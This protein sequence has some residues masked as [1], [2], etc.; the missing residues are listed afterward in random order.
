MRLNSIK[1]SGFKSFAEPTNFVLPGQLIGVV[2]PNGCGKSN[3]MD[4]VRWVLGESK[5][6][7]LRGE[8][9]QDVIFNGTNLRKP[10]SRSSVELVFDNADHRAGG[11]WGQFAE[12][13]V[14]RVLTRDGTSSYYLNNQPVRRRDVQ[15]V[16]LGTGLGPRAYAIIGQGTISRIIESKP[17]ELRLFLEEAAGV[18]KYKER[19][20]ET[21]NR[22]SDTRENLTRV[23]DILRELN[24]N[25][26][27]LEKQAEVALRY[28][29][30][31]ADATLKQHQL[32][33]LKRAESE[34]DQAK[35]KADAAK[36]VNDLESR[37]ADLRHIEADL[38]TIR[39]AHYAAGD[40]V[41]QAQGKLYE[42]S[43]EV[44]RLE[45]EI[46]FVVEGRQRVEQRLAQLKEQTSQWAARKED[47]ALETETLTERAIQAE[48]QAELLAAQSEDQAGQLPAL[49]EALRAAQSKANEQ[50]TSVGQVQQQ[51][52]VLA[53]DQRNIEEQ[54]RTLSLR[55]E[56]LTAD[57]NALN[58]PDEARL[59][60]LNT[61]FAAAKEAQDEAEARLH[62]L[63]DS[64]PQLDEDRRNKQQA[65]N[66]ESARQAELSAR[67]EALKALQEK[68]KTDGKLKPWLAKHGLDGLQGL[69]SRIHIEQGWENALEA[70][71]RERLGALE[72]SRLDMVRG[73]AGTDGR[74][75]P[76]AKLS[77]YSPPTATAPASASAS[78]LK[79][80]ADFL[81]LGD[82]GQ[83]AL[84]GD[85]L[86]GCL[87]AASLDE[88]LAA[89]HQLQA[90]EVIY[91]KSGHAVTLHS[92]SFYAQDS[93]Q[94]GLLARAQEIENLE[95]QLRAQALISDEARSAL[96]R[97][98][99]AYAD[100]A[101]RLATARRET[102]EGQSRTHELQVEVLRL[103][104]LAEQTRARSEQIAGDLAEIDA[105]MNDLQERRVTA[106]GR[107]EELDMQLADSQERHA[108]LDD[109]VIEAERKLN[110]SR[111][112]QRALERQSQE[113]QFALRSL[114]SRRDEL[115][116]S[117]DIAAQQAASIAGEEERAK[118]ELSRLT[119]AAA[120]AGL[121][122]AL[123]VKLEREADL[124]AKRSQY[125]DL[126]TKLRASD[127]RRLQLERELDPLR[128]RI[129]EFQLKEQAARLGFEQYA[130]L[131][132][133]AQADLAAVEQSIQTGN[134]R[135]TGLQGEI[136][137][138]N[139]DIQSLG[140]V[141]LAALDELSSA[142]ERKQ[143]LDA[144]SADLNEAMTTLE[145]AI[146]KI[147]AETRDLL[148]TTFETVNRHFGEMFPRLF[149][150]GNAKLV[151]TGE[152]IL[153]AGVQVLAQPP[154]K[155][156]QTIHLLSGGEK[157]L[158]AIALVFAIF[159]LN[160]APF[161][162]LDEVDAPLDDANTERYA[163]LVASMSKETQFLFISHNKIAMEMAEQLIGVT[164]QEQGVSRIVAVDMEAALG[165]A[166]AA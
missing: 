99:A 23:E 139:R 131:L 29:T 75:T 117:I 48:E 134:V 77:F 62:E 88:A 27:K 109:R 32:W 96:I 145:D 130:Q 37:I 20:R 66:T 163:K 93:E 104:Q 43:A 61:Q 90:G 149:G 55:H 98:E 51:I 157:A 3:I 151:M 166:E 148:S 112:Q 47:A 119:D 14:K 92:V 83:T 70:A 142:R 38:E 10:A 36:S 106:E 6:S 56:R 87:T 158:T 97:A 147:D 59:V 94:A 68:V 144:Q 13:A 101:Q 82:A 26:E 33:F 152:E 129:T 118:E 19:R 1:L 45:A 72:V 95:K 132:A 17:E 140:A 141:N 162:L 71:L 50:R 7:E 143:F 103:T 16:F 127:E 110:E 153:D 121:Q 15:D 64:V 124:G 113:A 128:Q 60:N 21:A 111:E 137:R 58:A 159:Q 115:T 69:W 67:L 65:V 79:P 12:I 135:L 28:N 31:H 100:A 54:S 86:H 18:S 136:D 22:L 4:A 80:L 24:A 52:Q 164:M 123:N 150:G 57:K 146:K 11:Q 125:D 138:I 25:L 41:N 39:Q 91:V 156:N 42:A 73:F 108:Q 78:G 114:A 53:A 89:R 74:D 35:V 8:S 49:E 40:Q 120:Q 160:P 34:A 5:A 9:M 126:T 154:G 76:P 44:G 116:R 165:F 2:G 84:L 107:F 81:R 161:C 63:T 122:D 155:K 102:A 85:W 30:L 46:R 105:Q 133:D